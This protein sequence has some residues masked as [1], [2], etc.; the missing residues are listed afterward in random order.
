MWS[1]FAAVENFRSGRFPRRTRT[2]ADQKSDNKK[3]SFDRVILF[4]LSMIL[5]Q[6]SSMQETNE[7]DLLLVDKDSAR[8][9]APADR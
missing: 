8:V 1:V 3:V 7:F 6:M 5:P 9:S 2:V 4:E